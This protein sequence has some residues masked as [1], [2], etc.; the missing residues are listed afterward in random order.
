MS[1][2][3]TSWAF[4]QRDLRPGPWVVLFQLAD[5]VNKDTYRYDPDQFKLAA[6][7]NMSR[8]SVNVRLKAL[9]DAGKIR[10]VK[11]FNK[12]K[13]KHLSTFY[14]LGL[15]FDRAIHIEHSMSRNWEVPCPDLKQ[16]RVQNPDTNLVREPIREPCVDVTVATPNQGEFKGFWESYP[17]PRNEQLSKELFNRAVSDGVDPLWIVRSAEMYRAENAGNNRQ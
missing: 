9:E 11:R 16:A 12:A 6:D 8:S 14:I 15:D 17:R 3:A 4:G 13:N 7:C 10:R 5:R 2:K 1:H